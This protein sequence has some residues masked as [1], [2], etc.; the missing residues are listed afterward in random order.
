MSPDVG[1]PEI[2]P[3]MVQL[4]AGSAVHPVPLASIGTKVISAMRTLEIW[5]PLL[6]G[7][8]REDVA[9]S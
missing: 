8:Q 6:V 4:S 1:S 2:V 7:L 5:L 3:P 9:H